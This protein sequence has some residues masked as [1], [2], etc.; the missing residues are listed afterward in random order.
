MQKFLIIQ[1]AFTGDVV[2]ATVVIE[3]LHHDFPNAQIDFLLRK[4]NESLFEYHPFLNQVLIWDKKRNKTK[5]LFHIL[6]QIRKIKYDKVINLQRFFSTGLLTVLSGAKQKIGFD[7]NPCSFLFST[8]VKHITGSIENPFHETERNLSI[9]KNITENGTAKMHLYPSLIHEKNVVSFKINPYICVAPASVW[10]TKQYPKEK[11]ISFLS[12]LPNHYSIYFIGAKTD[13]SLC[14]D[15]ISMLP[16]HNTVNFC[17]KLDFLSSAALMRDAIM[18]YANDSA[19]VHIAGSV[20]APITEI[21]CST[22]PSFGYGPL[23]TK[24]FV[25]ESLK[26][27]PCRPCGSHG[28]KQC[29]LQH[30]NC[31][32][33]IKE[34]QLLET[35]PG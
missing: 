15:I 19:P 28:K 8:R 14:D 24:S 5:N 2:L 21:Y 13:K 16:N 23:S 6:G 30:F 17:G 35:L 26:N 22:I 12:L 10:Y 7:K 1:T 4:G 9:L 31:A 32:F 34:D 18:N 29:P 33:T 20:N 3:Q 27:L 11:W 25:V